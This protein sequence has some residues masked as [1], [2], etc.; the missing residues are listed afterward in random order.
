VNVRRNNTM[1]S[2][3]SDRKL[4]MLSPQV[5]HNGR[6]DVLFGVRLQRISAEH[7]LVSGM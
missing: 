1:R 4:S 3:F 7:H 6:V 2:F 5:R